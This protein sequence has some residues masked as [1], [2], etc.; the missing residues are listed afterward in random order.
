[1]TDSFLARHGHNARELY[2]FME[3]MS[4]HGLVGFQD[5]FQYDELFV[6][7]ASKGNYDTVC[8]ADKQL[9]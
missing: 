9:S 5:T 7:T 8:I 6:R 4:Y 1:M 2:E 3:G